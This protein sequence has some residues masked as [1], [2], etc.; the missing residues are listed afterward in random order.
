M[1]SR[2]LAPAGSVCLSCGVTEVLLTVVGLILVGLPLLALVAD[3]VL[4]PPR[5]RPPPPVDSR[6]KLRRRCGLTWQDAQKVDAAVRQGRATRPELH[7]AARSLAE[8]VLTPPTFR[9]RP[10]TSY[11]KSA[12]RAAQMLLVVVVIGYGAA[13]G[14]FRDRGLGLF[15]LVIYG[16]LLLTSLIARRRRHQRAT[17]ALAANR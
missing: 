5:R 6:E 3:R 15:Y 11:P 4:P 8:L 10:V 1:T 7:A 13:L 12:R 17:V 2:R 14:M 9:G 16:S